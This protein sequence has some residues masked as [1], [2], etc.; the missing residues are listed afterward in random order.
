MSKEL[1]VAQANLHRSM[2]EYLNTF[3]DNKSI[4]LAYFA[5]LLVSIT[6]T[7]CNGEKDKQFGPLAQ[8]IFK[9]QG[10]N[11]SIDLP[12]QVKTKTCMFLKN[13]ISFDFMP[14]GRSPRVIIITATHIKK[15][16]PKPSKKKP[17][18]ITTQTPIIVEGG[19]GG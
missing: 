17:P 8:R 16:T 11:Y 18:L 3:L 2:N 7:G 14:G 4:R 19:S 9:L 1:H 10:Q 12:E 5:L 13:S 6:I 15:D